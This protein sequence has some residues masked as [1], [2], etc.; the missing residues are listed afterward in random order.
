MA[1]GELKNL[2]TQGCFEPGGGLVPGGAPGSGPGVEDPE[3]GGPDGPEGL[4]VLALGPC[5]G[6]PPVE[7]VLGCALGCPPAAGVIF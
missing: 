5:G 2:S 4:L 6:A 7:G 3:A 1:S